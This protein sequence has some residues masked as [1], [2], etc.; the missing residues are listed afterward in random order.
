M[1]LPSRYRIVIC[2]GPECGDKRGSAALQVELLR[3]IHVLGLEAR[4]EVGRQSCFGRCQSGPNVLVT[5]QP[6]GAA[7]QSRLGLGMFLPLAGSGAV[8]YNGVRLE[9]LRRI[10]EDHIVGGRPI[11]AML[12]R[13]LPGLESG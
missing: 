9:E 11:R 4:V 5:L 1:S 10:L 12:R 2:H 7:G 3:L 8:L 6:S 13:K